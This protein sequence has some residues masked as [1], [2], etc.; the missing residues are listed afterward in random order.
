MLARPSQAGHRRITRLTLAHNAELPELRELL[1]YYE[2]AQKRSYV[3]PELVD[4]LDERV[5]Q[6]VINWP[7]PVVDALEERIDLQGFRW[8]PC[9]ANG[10]TKHC[11]TYHPELSYGA[12]SEFTANGSRIPTG[13]GA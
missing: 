2:S 9:W 7:R 1:D 12:D 6:V 4:T 8:W 13:P 11:R 3:H 5:R 10:P